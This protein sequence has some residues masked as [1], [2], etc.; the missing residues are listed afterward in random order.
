MDQISA[1][2][3]KQVGIVISP[4]TGHQIKQALA[5]N[6]WALS[7]TFIPQEE[8]KGLAHAVMVAREFLGDDPFLMYLGDNLIGQSIEAFVREFGA[9]RPEALILLKEVEDPRMFGVAEVIYKTTEE[10]A[11][12]CEAGIIWNDLEIG[13]EWP[14]ERPI[15][16]PKDAVLPPLRA[17]SGT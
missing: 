4:E 16:S 3:I 5:G 14:I 17:V 13:I 9:T 1:V 11:P 12:E 2:G 10:Y 15:V 8:P 6:P 7:F